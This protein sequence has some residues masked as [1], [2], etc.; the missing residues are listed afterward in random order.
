MIVER[1][2]TAA[3]AY[4]N[5]GPI[6]NYTMGI[7][8]LL[9]LIVWAYFT[10]LGW[11]TIGRSTPQI[12]WYLTVGLIS[13][14]LV[15]LTLFSSMVI[16][17]EFSP[18]IYRDPALVTFIT[19]LGSAVPLVFLIWWYWDLGVRCNE[20]KVKA[21]EAPMCTSGTNGQ[22]IIVWSMAA[23]SSVFG[24]FVLCIMILAFADLYFR[25]LKAVAESTVRTAKQITPKIGPVQQPTEL[26]TQSSQDIL[27]GAG[28]DYGAEPVQSRNGND[29]LLQLGLGHNV[30][31]SKR[32]PPKR[33]NRR[34]RG[35]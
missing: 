22:V 12:A 14:P 23:V 1:E 4:K 24:F 18:T 10:I 33:K 7:L 31:I 17:G 30:R 20:S 16:L 3:G 11:A 15:A 21:I 28:E 34:L 19:A 29:L 26:G 32:T 8:L 35:R 6:L 25:R 5:R 2:A 13:L 27:A 9:M